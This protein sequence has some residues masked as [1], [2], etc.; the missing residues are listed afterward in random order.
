MSTEFNLVSEINTALAHSSAGRRGE[1]LR[2]VTDLFIA[3]A[4]ELSDQQIE[5]FD[6]VI[7]HLAVEIEL[8]ARALLAIRLAPIRNAPPHTIRNLAFDDAVDVAA[9]VLS[10]SEQLDD[11]DLVEN[12][13]T[14]GRGHML[15]ISRRS[16]LSEIVTDILIERGDR[17]VL[18]STVQNHAARLSESG[19][20]KLV[21]RSDADEELAIR[22]GER[23]EI[24]L[25]LFRQLIK[26]ASQYVRDK[27]E[28]AQPELSQQ[29]REVVAE[30]SE[31]IELDAIARSGDYSVALRSMQD[32]Q[33]RRQPHDGDLMKL[34]LTG[35][36]SGLI[37]ALAA[38]CDVPVGFVDKTIRQGQT[39]SLLVLARA[40][41]LSWP[42]VK[43]I[44][45]L[46]TR[47]RPFSEDEIAQSLGSYERLKSKTA[48][49]ILHFY[50]SREKR[51]SLHS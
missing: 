37:A 4:D 6:D 7:M 8:S 15:A 51:H 36:V 48:Q 47:R 10:Q 3:E 24:P 28:A 23:N 40:I 41:G 35:A 9:P 27:L 5:L 12:A 22:V 16:H 19:F 33:G 45:R 32:D 49:E 46:E 21:E 18:L 25:H 2:R 50:R 26:K 44:L 39:E 11:T 13:R 38:L 1:M 42:T 14:K 30:V 43:A 31:R 17:E 29:I 20:S 34:A